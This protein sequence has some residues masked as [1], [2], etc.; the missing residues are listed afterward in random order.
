M[1]SKILEIFGEA[2]ATPDRDQKVESVSGPVE[3]PKDAPAVAIPTTFSMSRLAA[4]V[5]KTFQTNVDHRRSSGVDAKL[6]KAL[7]AQTCSFTPDQREKMR[8]AGISEDIYAPITT[9]K[10]RA[11]KA[12]LVDIF[13]SAGDWPFTLKPTPDPDVPAQVEAE[14]LDSVKQDIDKIYEGL[15]S[16]GIQQL[17]PNAQQILDGIIFNAFNSRYDEIQHRKEEFARTRAKRMEKKVQDYFTEGGGFDQSMIKTKLNA[18][19]VKDDMDYRYALR[20]SM[21]ALYY[22]DA[23]M[24]VTLGMSVEDY[25]ARMG[26]MTVEQLAQRA[27][28]RMQAQAQTI[29]Q[30]IKPFPVAPVESNVI[31]SLKR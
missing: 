1:D 22:E 20:D 7:L 8:K 11:A 24:A 15:R 13:Q 4:F 26:G 10:I 23:K 2:I 28:R 29:T 5:M 21:N 6:R 12:M 25:Y 3:L 16:A 17:P 14:A 30:V 18:D 19:G 27:N 9:V 31:N